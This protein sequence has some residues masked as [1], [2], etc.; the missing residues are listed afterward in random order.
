MVMSHNRG[1]LCKMLESKKKFR[2]FDIS[3]EK[4]RKSPTEKKSGSIFG[5]MLS[6]REK[7]MCGIQISCHQKKVFLRW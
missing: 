4:K 7:K 3:R 5:T 2:V 1:G 6:L